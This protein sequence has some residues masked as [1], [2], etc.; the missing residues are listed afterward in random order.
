MLEPDQDPWD[1][2]AEDRWVSLLERH[3]EAFDSIDVLDDLACALE[4]HPEGPALL[5]V[6]ELQ[7]VLVE[8]AVRILRRAIDDQPVTAD[9]GEPDSVTLPWIDGVNRAAL[10]CLHTAHLLAF[11]RGELAAAREHAELL[12]RLNPDDNHGVRAEFMNQLL[13]D[14]DNEAA[15]DLAA[16]F[17]DDTLAEI[18]Y[19]RVLALVRLGREREAAAAAR[20]AVERLPEVRRYLLRDRAKQ[21]KVADYGITI[22][23]KDQAW[24]YREQMRDLWLATP[25][26][27][28]LIKR[29]SAA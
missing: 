28:A 22:G 15:L 26:A 18:P 10:R 3:P 14:G 19:G 17:A 6:G 21:P 2:D 1:P 8:R 11:D 5:A 24:F 23:G 16:R 20:E 9:S 7:R 12:L 13:R 29:G 27:L 4:L 25:A